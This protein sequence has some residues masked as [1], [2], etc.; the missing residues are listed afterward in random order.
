MRSALNQKG[1]CDIDNW[2]HPCRDQRSW[3]KVLLNLCGVDG[4]VTGV[5]KLPRLVHFILTLLII[6]AALVHS[7]VAVGGRA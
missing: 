5:D 1:A 6:D 3:L 4:V 7:K 2:T